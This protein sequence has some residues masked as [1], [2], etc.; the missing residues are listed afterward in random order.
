MVRIPG[1]KKAPF[2]APCQKLIISSMLFLAM[3]RFIIR[4]SRP[5]QT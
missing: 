2:R 3:P 5:K 4:A 1:Q